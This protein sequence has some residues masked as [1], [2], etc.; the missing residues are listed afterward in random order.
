MHQLIN[1]QHVQNKYK[2][3]QINLQQIPYVFANDL[4]TV[5]L[6]VATDLKHIRNIFAT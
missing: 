2:D 6:N 5:Y 4:Q 1:S 3:F